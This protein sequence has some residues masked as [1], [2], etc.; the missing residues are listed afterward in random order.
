MR[1][2]AD[3]YMY[4]RRVS[5]PGGDRNRVG[6]HPPTTEKINTA[7]HGRKREDDKENGG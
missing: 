3:L 5:K 7:S 6:G 2:Y 4:I 1:I